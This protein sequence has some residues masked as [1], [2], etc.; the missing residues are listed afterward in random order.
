MQTQHH[1]FSA[2]RRTYRVRSCSWAI[3]SLSRRCS[4]RGKWAYAKLVLLRRHRYRPQNIS[5][6]V[7]FH[8]SVELS[9]FLLGT[10]YPS[11][12]ELCTHLDASVKQ[13]YLVRIVMRDKVDC[14]HVTVLI[15]NSDTW[16]Q[17]QRTVSNWRVKYIQN[18][19]L[20]RHE[21]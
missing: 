10:K 4:I 5:S 15:L 21:T 20:G 3:D 9:V 11:F 14:V 8:S 13:L 7:P 2:W 16:F 12:Q 18:K 17:S 1:S 6:T 19:L